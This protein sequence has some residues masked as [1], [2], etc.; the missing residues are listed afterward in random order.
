MIIIALLVSDRD[1]E[2]VYRATEMGGD[3][4]SG[5]QTEIP[6]KGIQQRNQAGMKNVPYRVRNGMINLRS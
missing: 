1:P 3:E 2:E 6:R 5:S 4:E